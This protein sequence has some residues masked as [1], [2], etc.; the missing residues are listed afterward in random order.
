MITSRR[1]GR[2]GRV[3]DGRRFLVVV[4]AISMLALVPLSGCWG[5]IIWQEAMCW[6]DAYTDWQADIANWPDVSVRIVNN[7]DAT[8][9]VA[10]ATSAI[11]E[12]GCGFGILGPNPGD[13]NYDE[14]DSQN[15][16]VS[17]NGTA[18]G[19]IKCGEIFGVSV[20]APYDLP[21]DTYYYSDYGTYAYGMYVDAGNITLSGAGVSSDSGFTGDT[22]S[23]FR[24][25][26]QV[27]DNL[28]CDADTLVITIESLGTARV[29]DPDTGAIISSATPGTGTVS[30]E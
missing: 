14:A 23:L 1:S 11:W 5:Y 24:Y 19:T 4:G 3:G 13:P 20:A 22:V 21:D 16:L 2:P 15:L 17:A 8:A 10:L 7:T 29:I 6:E 30:I 12:S 9:R 25:V 28:D 18:T 27:E 26:R